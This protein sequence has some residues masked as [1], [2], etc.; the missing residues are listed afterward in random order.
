[1]SATP[2]PTIAELAELSRLALTE[3]ELATAAREI[4]HLRAYIAR[5]Q[6]IGLEAATAAPDPDGADAPLRPDLARQDPKSGRGLSSA[7]DRRS[8]HFAVPKVLR[9]TEP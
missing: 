7:P 9:R 2:E 8:D 6:G 1:M 4:D 5:I 3:R